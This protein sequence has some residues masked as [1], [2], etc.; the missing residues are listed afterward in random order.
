MFDN[1][2]R[3]G[4][5]KKKVRK[6][7]KKRVVKKRIKTVIDAKKLDQQR[8]NTGIGYIGPLPYPVPAIA[9][10][11]PVAQS[12]DIFDQARKQANLEQAKEELDKKVKS[13]EDVILD[14]LRVKFNIPLQIE[15]K[16]PEIQQQDVKKAIQGDYQV[17]EPEEKK[18][19]KKSTGMIIPREEGGPIIKGVAGRKKLD[20]TEQER[21]ERRKEQVKKAVKKNREKKKDKQ[22][23][24]EEIELL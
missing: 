6:L 15:D 20:I 14:K 9:S 22:L 13:I 2:K 3:G 23:K 1:Y 16:A 10:V 12:G 19:S 7:K 5:I 8:P 18:Q 21:Q 17:E 11:A 24:E 4:K